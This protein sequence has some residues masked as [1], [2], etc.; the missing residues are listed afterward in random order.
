MTDEEDKE[1]EE[2]TE[3]DRQL[4]LAMRALRRDKGW[5][6]LVGEMQEWLEELRN[7]YESDSEASFDKLV[8][9]EFVRGEIFM[10]KSIISYPDEIEQSARFALRARQD[11]MKEQQ[12]DGYD[13]TDH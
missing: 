7:L 2:L 5:E 1:F 3:E 11:Q 4:V 8:G 6:F 13:P 10:L 9:R 12:S